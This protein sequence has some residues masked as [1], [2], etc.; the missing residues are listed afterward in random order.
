M[1]LLLYKSISGEPFSAIGEWKKSELAKATE[2]DFFI[3]NSV[4]SQC[5]AFT[6]TQ[7]IP[8]EACKDELAKIQ[9]HPSEAV[10]VDKAT[11]L[12]GLEDFKNEM[13]QKGIQKA[14]YSRIEG[15]ESEV[16]PLAVFNH[17]CT[18]YNGKALVYLIAS[19]E[20]GVWIGATPE[21][22]L[23]GDA[24]S[25]KTVS[26]A[27]TKKEEK[28]VWTSKEIEEQAFVT[29][30][31][32]AKL[33]EAGVTNLHKGQPNTIFSG[34]VFHLSTEF[35][36]SFPLQHIAQLIQELHPTP[37]VCGLPREQALDLI[38]SHEPHERKW[39]T[40]VLGYVREDKV[41]T[42]VNL[43]CMEVNKDSY[44]LYL[45]GGITADSVPE[46]EWEETQNK[47]NTLKSVL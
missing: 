28:Q 36:F 31:I 26:L 23:Q 42:F 1:G 37:A 19:D 30:F 20:F 22:L 46:K 34:S 18:K 25:L 39:Y 15:V 27:G 41:M 32:Q 7:Q 5:V 24:V 10:K 47:A 16:H 43:R 17:L 9:L 21:V 8:L 13:L 14:I 29:D 45:G 6:I 11:Y 12:K 44:D 2:Y 40:G 38:R 33:E 35:S 4:L 3:T